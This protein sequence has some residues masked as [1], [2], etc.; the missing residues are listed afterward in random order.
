MVLEFDDATG[1]A[2]IRYRVQVVRPVALETVRVVAVKAHLVVNLV[3][4]LTCEISAFPLVT[5][6][7]LALKVITRLS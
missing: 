2:G 3:A 7:I 4:L 5:C 1:D 6:E